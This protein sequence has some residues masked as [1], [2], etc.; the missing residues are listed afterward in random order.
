MP[1]AT[2]RYIRK[3]KALLRSFYTVLKAMDAHLEFV[4]LTGVTKYSHDN[5]Y[6]GLNNLN[7]ISLDEDYASICGFTEQE[8]RENL[9]GGVEALA[10]R[11]E[12][13]L[14]EAYARLKEMYGGYRFSPYTEQEVYNPY[15]LLRAISSSNLNNCWSD[16]GT[17]EFLYKIVTS[18]PATKQKGRWRMAK[19]ALT[20]RPLRKSRLA[21]LL[22]QPGYLTIESSSG[23]LLPVYTLR[24]PNR[25]RCRSLSSTG[26]WASCFTRRTR[27]TTM[28]SFL[29]WAK[30]RWW[31]LP[32]Y[33]LEIIHKRAL[34]RMDGMQMRRMPSISAAGLKTACPQAHPPRPSR[35]SR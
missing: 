18:R 3:N 22:Y 21:P 28:S 19:S 16:S 33:T 4:L 8:L 30:E 6:S 27:R 17:P 26:C 32:I 34:R 31:N 14:E 23:G 1:K 24:F 25:E 10:E 29:R 9:A 2:N 13:T 11:Q 20:E 35:R 7:D 15:S 5:M 12:L